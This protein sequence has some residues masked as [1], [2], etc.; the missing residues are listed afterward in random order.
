MAYIG[1][2]EFFI[3]VP[4]LPRDEFERYSTQLFDDWESY[5]DSALSLPDYSIALETEEGSVKAVGRVAA[6]LGVLYIGIGQYGSFINGLETI[7]RQVRDVGDY[8]SD[9]AAAPFEKSS[10]KPKV[11]RRGESLA[12]LKT[13]F[14]KVQRGEMTVDQAMKE[15]ES[16][17]GGELEEAPEFVN[18]LEDSLAKAPL[19][20]RQ[21]KLPLVDALGN[22]LIPEGKKRRKSKRPSQP[23]QPAPVPEHY[24]VELWR[25]S[26][27]SKRNVRVSTW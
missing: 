24:R 1:S 13:L 17:F 22:D 3:D 20:P 7:D 2:T 25:E 18:A 12:R 26:K 14:D 16:V 4:S 10:T 27:K 19:F 21:I 5:V 6:A 9:R 11:K 23:T 15:A 8:F